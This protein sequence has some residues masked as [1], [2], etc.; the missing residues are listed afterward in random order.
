MENLKMPLCPYCEKELRLKL[1]AQFV[2]QIDEKYH[3]IMENQIARLPGMMKGMMRSQLS[4]IQ[5]Q[6]IMVELLLCVECDKVIYADI[7][8]QR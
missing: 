2:T 1:S 4:Q 5:N 7:L 3:Q 8:R 6:P